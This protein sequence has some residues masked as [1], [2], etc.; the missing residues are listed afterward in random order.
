MDEYLWIKYAHILG[1]T[2]IF[3]TG[4]GTAFQM[5]AAHRSRDVRGLALVTRNVVKADWIFTTPAVLLQPLTGTVLAVSAGYGLHDRWL[6]GAILLYG[7]T[8]LCWLPV[9][10]IQIKLRDLAAQ[11]AATSQ[12][13]PA[14]YDRLF[15]WWFV[16]GVPA[17]GS[18]LVIFHLMIQKPTF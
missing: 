3:G 7:L 1:A 9:V 14:A 11:A 2:V 18:V 8:G 6:L 16:L 5:W 10:W 15:R 13:L 12:P 17:F 4:I